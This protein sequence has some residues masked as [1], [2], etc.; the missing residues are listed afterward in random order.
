MSRRLGAAI[1]ALYGA[2][3]VWR[4]R[5]VTAD[6]W[7][8]LHT[9]MDALRPWP[10][11][12]ALAFTITRPPVGWL[13][14][15]PV[16]G[17]AQRL[18]GRP[19]ALEAA[20]VAMAALPAVILWVSWRLYSRALSA[21][22]AAAA[23]LGLAAN[24][25]LLRYAPFPLL[26][27]FSAL[28]LLPFLWAGWRWCEKPTARSWALLLGAYV[29]AVLSRYQFCL[30]ILAPAAWA[31]WK[32]GVKRAAPLAALPPLCYGAC[33]LVLAA[34]E[35]WLGREPW[36]F[37]LPRASSDFAGVFLVN[38]AGKAPAEWSVYLVSLWE[39][40]GPF[41]L[42]LTAGGLWAWLRGGGVG[43]YA[44]LSVVL[45]LAALSLLANKEQRYA[46]SF[47]PALYGAAGAGL[48]AAASWARRRGLPPAGAAL[49]ACVLLPWTATFASWEFIG[50]DDSLRSGVFWRA[51][52]AVGSAGCVGWRGPEVIL[53]PT[54]RAIAV[55]EQRPTLGA[56]TL[57]FFTTARVVELSPDKLLECGPRAI[58][59]AQADGTW[60]VSGPDSDP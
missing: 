50:K 12:E 51:A 37:A 16:V 33:V 43:R 28:A 25:L 2:L 34:L 39:Q 21:P 10:G 5:G 19:A 8:A 38:V 20:H 53:R 54:V 48:D 23:A 11:G 41:W 58:I 26:D 22:A 32:G 7:D 44:A 31:L 24:P 36:S 29:L 40:L 60:K 27:V 47:L 46:L 4:C 17:L 3:V 15:S 56:P 42:A 57:S 52:A 35:A 55:D 49:A 14:L 6:Y 18:G 1:A 13:L 45:P 30:V 59:E 9:L